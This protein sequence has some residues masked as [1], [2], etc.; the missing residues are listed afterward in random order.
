MKKEPNRFLAIYGSG[1]RPRKA[2]NRAPG[3]GY[4]KQLVEMCK[5]AGNER[6]ELAVAAQDG[7]L[8]A[9][10]GQAHESGLAHPLPRKFRSAHSRNRGERPHGPRSGARSGASAARDQT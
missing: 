4:F 2:Q 1:S 6:P 8:I 3:Q 10:D 7:E 5:D 9:E